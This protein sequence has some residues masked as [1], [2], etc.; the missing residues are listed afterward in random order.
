MMPSK[1]SASLF[2]PREFSITGRLIDILHS[3]GHIPLRGEDGILIQPRGLGRSRNE[4]EAFSTPPQIRRRRLNQV[5]P[6]IVH[7]P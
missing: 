3:T 1:R 6:P 7:T 5:E 4:A 2:M